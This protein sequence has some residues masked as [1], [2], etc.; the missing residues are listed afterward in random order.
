MSSLVGFVNFGAP[1]SIRCRA[2][3]LS[4]VERNRSVHVCATG[5]RVC[6]IQLFAQA[7]GSEAAGREVTAA[8]TRH[9]QVDSE[10]LARGLLQDLRDDKETA[11]EK[12]RNMALVSTC[13]TKECDGTVG[14]IRKGT[15][16]PEL[17]QA[18]FESEL[19]EFGLVKSRLGWHVFQ[20]DAKSYD[21]L[22]ISM[23][24]FLE[25]Y[26]SQIDPEKTQLVDVRETKELV[27]PQ[28]ELLPGFVN[29]PTSE[30]PKWGPDLLAG[31]LLDK[32]KETL[33]MCKS[34]VRAQQMCAFF[35]QQGVRNLKYIVG[36]MNKYL[37]LTQNK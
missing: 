2:G 1:V 21:E 9:I 36:G 12:F 24:D 34:G 19:G 4:A 29:I 23:E 11:A 20:V 13:D 5:R 30:Y 6:S 37:S 25:R 14:W 18:A 31:K 16:V 10:E 32:E 3:R 35:A 17:E 15:M 26:P 28:Y 8:Y 33:V 27:E 7:S 22:F